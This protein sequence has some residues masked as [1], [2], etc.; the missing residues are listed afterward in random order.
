V[1][2]P[3]KAWACPEESVGLPRRKRGRQSLS[4]GFIGEI[5]TLLHACGGIASRLSL[6]A[7]FKRRER[8]KMRRVLQKL[9]SAEI[10]HPLKS[11]NQKASLFP[12]SPFCIIYTC[13][14][15]HK[16]YFSYVT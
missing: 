4:K 7:F 15:N 11:A 13:V 16:Y 8:L 6:F 14:V 1:P 10:G 9:F 5:A 2:A 12:G 3:K